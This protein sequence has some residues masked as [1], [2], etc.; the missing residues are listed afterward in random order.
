MIEFQKVYLNIIEQQNNIIS[1][2]VI[3]SAFNFLAN[4]VPSVDSILGNSQQEAS[5][6]VKNVVDKT[7][8]KFFAV[9]DPIKKINEKGKKLQNNIIAPYKA[10]A[11]GKNVDEK[12]EKNAAN[13]A[14]WSEAQITNEFVK[15]ARAQGL[16][17]KGVAAEEKTPEMIKQRENIILQ[18]KKEMSA[19]M[20]KI[21]VQ[22]A[23]LGITPN[24][25]FDSNAT[26]EMQKPVIFQDVTYNFSIIDKKLICEQ[27][28]NKNNKKTIIAESI[29]KQLKSDGQAVRQQLGIS[30]EALIALGLRTNGGGFRSH[31][32]D[33]KSIE[34]WM[35]KPQNQKL[36]KK[37][38]ITRS[39]LIE[40]DNAYK[41]NKQNSG[42]LANSGMPSSSPDTTTGNPATPGAT[43]GNPTTPEA[44]T[45]TSLWQK[46]K[47]GI[48]TFVRFIGKIVLQVIIF[49]A[50]L[51]WF[52]VRLVI[53]GA[54]AIA[55]L[56]M[57]RGAGGKF[58]AFSQCK[59]DVQRIFGNSPLGERI[60]GYLSLTLVGGA[61]M[62]MSLSGIKNDNQQTQA[63][64]TPETT[65]LVSDLSIISDFQV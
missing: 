39:N 55:K 26:P 9:G 28:L 51:I 63:Q 36:M 3:D 32:K 47:H 12:I 15:K 38:H 19:Y 14:D 60:A 58:V 4:L 37:H 56:I 49:I 41:I 64:Q 8:G 30:P 25:W 10:A 33:Y 7:N 5:A 34:Q 65:H 53:Q 40:L 18:Y 52:L 17:F 48:D 21:I 43:T 59:A 57:K 31:G 16:K 54:K 29:I 22:D 23:K 20:K 35:S 62:V 2:G 61:V 6:N 11:T 1:E 45:K 13:S 24:M 42:K 46:I 44:S 27:V 50:T